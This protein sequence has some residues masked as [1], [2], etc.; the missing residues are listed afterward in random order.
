MT[1][2]IDITD[3]VFG[4][5]T[6]IRRTHDTG[7][8]WEFLCSC[9]TR[10]IIAK[11]SVTSGNTKS[12]G[13][14]R[15]ALMR[16]TRTKHGEAQKTKEYEAWQSM[17]ARCTRPKNKRY[18]LYGGRGITVCSAW[19]NSFEKFLEDMG[20]AP[21]KEHSLDRIDVNGNYELSNCRW[22]TKEEQSNN[23]TN[24]RV[25]EYLGQTKTVTQWAGSTGISA[26]MLRD[27]LFKLNW[28]VEKSLNTPRR[29]AA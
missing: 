4:N 1:R 28:S 16:Q 10:V 11:G 24:N 26:S 29:G 18:P 17:K 6:A 8:K 2:E 7:N 12:C 27:R 25:L 5:L 22:A 19:F 9:G 13:C 23:K 15:S 20:R 14:L 21:S 3:H